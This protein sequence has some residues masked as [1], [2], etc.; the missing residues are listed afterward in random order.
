MVDSIRINLTIDD[1]E[2]IEY[3]GEA[4]PKKRANLAR[5]LMNFGLKQSMAETGSVSPV[6][7]QDKPKPKPKQNLALSMGAAELFN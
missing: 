1:P 7:P 4:S 2:I 6:T 5:K 3:L